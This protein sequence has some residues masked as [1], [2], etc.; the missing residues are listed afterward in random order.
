MKENH[1]V[2]T[3][4][5]S[6][7]ALCQTEWVKNQ[8]AARYADIKIGMLGVTTQADKLLSISLAQVGGKGL[9]VKELEQALLEKRADIAVHSMKDMPMEYPA[10]LCV[11]V[12]CERE[13]VRDVFISNRYQSLSDLPKGSSIGTSSLRRQSQLKAIR[14]DLMIESLRGNVN[15]RL[16]RL[17]EGD[18]DAIILAA[19]GMKRLGLA[20]RIT[21]FLSIEEIL[22]AV[23]QGALALECRED[24]IQVQ[25]RIQFLN[26][27]PSTYCVTAERAMC[28]EL[29]GGCQVPVAAYAEIKNQKILLRGLVGSVDGKTILRA[30]YQS[31]L[32][33]AVQIGKQ[34][35]ENLLQQGADKI[36]REFTS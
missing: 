18:F 23:G 5:E 31:D 33:Q 10:G 11:P 28:R 2:I 6:P 36:L 7:L 26:H 21:S 25:A 17:D 14:P 13:D 20:E 3:T 22:P 30:Q 35:A 9:F 34:V 4:R 19:A 16:K 32:D 8:M 27:L 1:I 29:G 12:V 24:D 15:T